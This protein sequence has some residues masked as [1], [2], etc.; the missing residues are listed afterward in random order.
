MKPKHSSIFLFLSFI[1]VPAVFAQVDETQSPQI[2]IGSN[3]PELK[4]NNWVKGGTLIPFE[5][6]KIYLVDLWATWCVPC[7]AGMP[8]LSMLQAKYK[9][10][11]LEIIGITSED[12][13]GNSFDKVKQFVHRKDSVMNYHVAWA[14][15]SKKDS[16][17]GIWL[18]P[19]MLQA[20]LGNLPTAFLI[21]RNGKLVFIGE[22]LS[23]DS[24]LDDVIKDRHNITALKN[25][26]ADAIRAEEVL[27]K[28]NASLKANKMEEAVAWG[29]QILSNFSY[30]KPNTFL[31]MGWQVSRLKGETDPKLLQ[32]GYEAAIRG[33]KLTNFESPGFLDVLAAI[34]AARKDYLNA[35][36]TEKLAVSLSEGGMKDGQIDNLQRYLSLLSKAGK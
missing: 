3:A 31:I 11:G 25:D 12:K 21:D 14:P 27:S 20:G 35:V 32:V 2:T 8:H 23:I 17:E 6:G 26:Y 18:H 1:F 7:I 9:S 13:F 36:I 15:V 30:V 19:W 29:N 33:V 5:K 22:P 34:H 24:I 28:F 16:V 4:I 10:I